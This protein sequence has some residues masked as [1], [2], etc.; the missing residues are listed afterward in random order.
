MT[1]RLCL[2]LACALV[3]IALLSACGGSSN[4]KAD[5]RAQQ[6][7]A[8]RH[9]AARAYADCRRATTNSALSP[10]ERAILQSECSDIKSGNASALTSAGRQLCVLEASQLPNPERT[11]VLARCKATKL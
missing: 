5:S 11:T 6:L 9:N 3:P 2:L 10:S 1:R 8:V 7:S 4:S